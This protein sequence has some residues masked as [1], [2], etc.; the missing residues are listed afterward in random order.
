[1]A[2]KKATYHHFSDKNIMNAA[3]FFM[4]KKRDRQS[5]QKKKDMSQGA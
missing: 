3:G 5:F 1:M 4:L 2:E